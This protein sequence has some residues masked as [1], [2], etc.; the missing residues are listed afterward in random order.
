MSVD[1]YKIIGVS[2]DATLQQIKAAFRELAVRYH[3]DNNTED[4]TYKFQEITEAY[5]EV[6]KESEKKE[7][8]IFKAFSYYYRVLGLHPGASAE[9]VKRTYYR[10]V[11]EHSG[12]DD[13]VD[14][15]SQRRIR[16]INAAY[17]ALIGGKKQDPED[18]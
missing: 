1:Y 8:R 7:S 4:T 16:E 2:R 10:L 3:P 15:G 9:Q 11:S 5:H 17:D 18:W 13:K 12:E 14:T 6:R